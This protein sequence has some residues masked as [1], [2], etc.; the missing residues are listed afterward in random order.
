M[1]IPVT[2]GVASLALT[3]QKKI[4]KMGIIFNFFYSGCAMGRGIIIFNSQDD[5]GGG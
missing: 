5:F 2:L 3:L 1:G 4:I